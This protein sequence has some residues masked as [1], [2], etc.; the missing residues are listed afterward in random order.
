[1]ISLK[2]ILGTSRVKATSMVA[3]GDDVHVL[4]EN[5]LSVHSFTHPATGK[6]KYGMNSTD[7]DRNPTIGRD[8]PTLFS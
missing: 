2:E 5:P 1:M 7:D 8:S 4:T 3:V 6:K